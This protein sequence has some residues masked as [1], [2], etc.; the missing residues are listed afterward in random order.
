MPVTLFPFSAFIP[1]GS[2]Y[3]REL[4]RFENV[5][6]IHGGARSLRE[7]QAVASVASG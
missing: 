5:L 2:A 4:D 7:K 3:G 1:D 6:P